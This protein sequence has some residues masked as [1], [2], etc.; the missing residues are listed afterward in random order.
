MAKEIATIKQEAQVVRYQKTVGGNTAGRVG[1]VLEDITDYLSE[2]LTT[3]TNE[4]QDGSVTTPKIADEA[5]TNI[6]LAEGAVIESKLAD[7][8]VTGDKISESVA[9]A[10]SDIEDTLDDVF[11]LETE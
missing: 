3:G 11:G 2:R 1:K 4:L 10:S 5:V 7:Y 6:K 9:V 8:A